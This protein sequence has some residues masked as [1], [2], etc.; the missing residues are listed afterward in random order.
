MAVK[1]AILGESV[2]RDQFLDAGLDRVCRAV[3]HT[4]DAAHRYEVAQ[5]YPFVTTAIRDAAN[6]DSVLDPIEREC[7][8]RPPTRATS[9]AHSASWTAPTA[10]AA[11]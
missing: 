6:R 9:N 7:G 4:L 3:T 5:L 8:V 10:R 11:G 1:A 2:G